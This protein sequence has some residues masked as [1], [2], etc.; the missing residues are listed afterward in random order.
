MEISQ[1]EYTLYPSGLWSILAQPSSSLERQLCSAL[2]ERTRY[3]VPS[4][5]RAKC[6]SELTV[7]QKTEHF[8]ALVKLSNVKSVKNTTGLPVL[9][10]LSQPGLGRDIQVVSVNADLPGDGTLGRLCR[11]SLPRPTCITSGRCWEH[12]PTLSPFN[13]FCLS[14]GAVRQL[15]CQGR[16]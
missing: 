16:R 4:E 10:L 3:I 5:E 15:C 14:T 7:L 13:T 9:L 11:A 8:C 12:P 2:G 1:T 6:D